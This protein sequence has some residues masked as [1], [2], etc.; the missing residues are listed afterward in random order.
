MRS[1][2]QED[3]VQRVVGDMCRFGMTSQD[4]NGVGLVKKPTA[5]LTNS[6]CIA[7]ELAV[8]CTKGH[9]HVQLIGGRASA[10]EVYPP[11]LCRAI[12]RGLKAQPKEMGRLHEHK[13]LLQACREADLNMLVMENEMDKL[14][15]DIH[16]YKQCVD[17]E[18][19]KLLD[20][21]M[22]RAT[23]D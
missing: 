11:E 7:K 17:Y 8:K 1:L 20:T 10:A 14:I 16:D 19:G 15:N 18:S 3:G 12:L 13:P 6:D 9:S 2:I 23:R 22:A 5:Y 21:E 4:V